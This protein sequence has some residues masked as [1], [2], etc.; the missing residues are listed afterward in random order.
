MVKSDIGDS[1]PSAPPR[2]AQTKRNLSRVAAVYVAIHTT[3]GV[4]IDAH[5]SYGLKI[6][7]TDDVSIR[8]PFTQHDRRSSAVTR[9]SSLCG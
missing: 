9:R 6:K 8:D 2:C 7:L 1:E 3:A 4:W 5:L